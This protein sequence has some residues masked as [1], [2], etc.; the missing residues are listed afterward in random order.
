MSIEQSLDRIA[1]ALEKLV[2]V[3]CNPKIEVGDIVKVTGVTES[4]FDKFESAI[5]A[6]PARKAGRPA[7]VVA[8]PVLEAAPAV[9]TKDDVTDTLREY[10]R[11]KGKE[12]EKN[13][14][15]ILLEFGAGRISEIDPKHYADLQ[16]KL[17]AA[18]K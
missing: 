18:L 14:K 1:T 3:K 16:S 9:V 2:D 7:K 11:V 12:G 8:E 4:T 17:K 6:A 5:T 15:T 13:A 10:V